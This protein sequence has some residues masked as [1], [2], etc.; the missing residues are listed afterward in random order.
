MNNA[1]NSLKEKYADW[2]YPINENNAN[3]ALAEFRENTNCNTL[4]E[5]TCAV[6]SGLFMNKHL[7][8]IATREL[9]L[10]LLEA[11]EYF[12]KSFFEI[13]FAYRHPYIDTSGYK[14]LLDRNGFVKSDSNDDEN[15]FDL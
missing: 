11:N 9:C 2:P 10:P 8:T 5:L 15:P 6:C 7:T 4:R 1:F 12:N 14:I 3:N 13:D